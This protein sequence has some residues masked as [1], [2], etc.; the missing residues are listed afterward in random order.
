MQQVITR[1]AVVDLAGA[2]I[3]DDC[4]ST[5]VLRPDGCCLGLVQARVRNTQEAITQLEQQMEAMRLARA[6]LAQRN[7][8]LEREYAASSG[9]WDGQVQLVD[10]QLAHTAAD[11]P[12]GGGGDSCAAAD[13]GDHS[14]AGGPAAVHAEAAVAAESAEEHG[15]AMSA[16]TARLDSNGQPEAWWLTDRMQVR[17]GADLVPDQKDAGEAR[18]IPVT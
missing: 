3:A 15:A 9:S 1:L 7:E 5:L 2:G 11:V 18:C 10:G 17:H 12:G 14:A 13:A 16:P 4:V 6:S 8:V